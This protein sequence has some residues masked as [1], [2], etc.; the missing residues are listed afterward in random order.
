MAMSEITRI[1]NVENSPQVVL[2]GSRPL[3]L[4]FNSMEEKAE[5]YECVPLLKEGVEKV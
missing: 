4:E 1:E 2:V 5:F 3:K